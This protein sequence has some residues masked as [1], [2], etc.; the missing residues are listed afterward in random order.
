MTIQLPL[1]FNDSS[2]ILQTEEL[3]RD[4]CGLKNVIAVTELYCDSNIS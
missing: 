1:P 4:D 2:A 3:V